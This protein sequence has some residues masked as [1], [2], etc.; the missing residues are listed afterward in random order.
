MSLAAHIAPPTYTGRTDPRTFQEFI[1]ELNRVA[2]ALK[3][4][5]EAYLTTLPALLRGEA[6][7]IYES[8]PPAERK[9][10]L[11]LKPILNLLA[12]KFANTQLTSNF[13]RRALAR[14]Q[15]ANESPSEFAQAIRDLVE[16]GYPE[17]TSYTDAFKEEIMVDIFLSGLLPVVKAKLLRKER[18][19]TLQKALDMAISE[20]ELQEEL[21]RDGLINAG[22]NISINQLQPVQPPH[23]QMNRFNKNWQPRRPF[24]RFFSKFNNNNRPSKPF[25]FN[26]N[27]S[28]SNYQPRANYRPQSNNQNSNIRNRPNHPR[29]T[30]YGIN[31]LLP[32][33]TIVALAAL[34]VLPLTM[35]QFQFCPL[36]KGALYL[37]P[38]RKEDC[39][40][41]DDTPV[42]KTNVEIFVPQLGP[43]YQEAYHC[44]AKKVTRCT[45]SIGIAAF[46]RLTPSQHHSLTANECWTL[47][48]RMTLYNQTLYRL[49]ENVWQSS[50]FINAQYAV[51]GSR[52]RE[53]LQFTVTKGLIHSRNG[54]TVSS[55]ID[56]L[57]N[58]HY[59]DALCVTN[60]G[61]TVWNVT[62]TK[63]FC[64]HT[65][66]GHFLA[67]ASDTYVIIQRLQA[68]F[69]FNKTDPDVHDSFCYPINTYRMENDVFISF[70]PEYP[71]A[72]KPR[73]KRFEFKE[74][75]R[76]GDTKPASTT[77]RTTQ[78]T[79]PTSPSSAIETRV[80]DRNRYIIP[81]VQKAQ[82]CGASNVSTIPTE[83]SINQVI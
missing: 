68:A 10:E 82:C 28:R 17:S 34:S 60:Q 43:H 53:K 21:K 19:K 79:A 50:G 26:N 31:A 49:D 55:E 25:F 18:P 58:C 27:T 62:D 14:K 5:D 4:T 44:Q 24:N 48:Q 64:S 76:I 15:R 71:T 83:I 59:N 77:S 54:I 9:K 38:P 74:Q 66:A 32:S 51:F 13:R 1:R 30:R 11:G 52:C 35:A 2:T 3:W 65:S 23:A 42:R 6:A 8:I 57:H 56:N 47:I 80:Q 40:V 41:A 12:K 22:E 63:D 33:L 70:H 73:T 29:P 61:T 36:R 81:P 45:F 69:V 16:L 37:A 7:I 72:S 39:T 46:E 78:G 20:I 75:P 67:L